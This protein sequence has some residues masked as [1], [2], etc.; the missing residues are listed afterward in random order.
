MLS[1]VNP[2]FSDELVNFLKINFPGQLTEICTAMDL[3]VHSLNETAED[4]TARGSFLLKSRELK[5]AISLLE[6]AKELNILSE[7][8]QDYADM[9]QFEDVVLVSED[10]ILDDLEKVFPNYNEYEVDKT[11]VH[12]LH[13]NYVHKRPYAFELKGQRI[14]VRQWK[15][16]LMETCNIMVDIDPGLIAEFPYIQKLNGRRTQYFTVKN[17]EL[18]RSPRKLK[19]IEMY[20]ETNFSANV[21]RDLIKKIIGYYKIPLSEFKIYLRAD[22]TKLHKTGKIDDEVDIKLEC[23][24]KEKQEKRQRATA[25]D[26]TSDCIQRISNYLNKNLVKRSKAIYRTYDDKTAVV[27]LT[28][29]GM[30]KGKRTEYWFGLRIKQKEFL[31]S[32]ERSYLALGCGLADKIFLIPYSVFH[33]WLGYMSISGNIEQIQHWNIVVIEKQGS[34]MLRFK[35]DRQNI[36]LK[37]YMLKPNR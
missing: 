10:E 11:V 34:L 28:S 16:M 18:M 4:V 3:L 37:N 31:E 17:P 1:E 6:K 19:K 21:I 23:G 29:R 32:A 30:N 8:I 25:L 22:Y 9:L 5:K 14:H 24:V 15:K 36:N 35:G 12:T 33:N 27:C 7:K 13:E 2:L 26:I 20:V